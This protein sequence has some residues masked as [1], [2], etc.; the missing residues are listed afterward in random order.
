MDQ[1]DAIFGATPADGKIAIEAEESHSIPPS[2]PSPSVRDAPPIGDAIPTTPMSEFANRVM[3]A[4]RTNFD[5]R[6]SSGTT[7]RLDYCLRTHKK[8]FSDEQMEKLRQ[9]FPGSDIPER[10]FSPITSVKNR[11]LRSILVELVNQVGEPLFKVESSP[12][13]D[14]G[15]DALT[16]ALKITMVEIEGLLQGLEAQG[17]RDDNVPPEAVARLSELVQTTFERRYDDIQNV[18][19]SELRDRAKKMEKKV[20]D[21]FE[22]GGWNKAFM[23]AIDDFCV[24][25]TAVILGPVMRNVA[26]N[27]VKTDKNDVKSYRR[28]VKCIP[29]FERVNPL[30]C[31][32]APDAVEVD[33]G[34][35][36][37]TV[38]F[39]GEE[40]YRLASSAEGTDTSGGGWMGVIVNDILSRHTH[41]GVKLNAFAFDP[42]RR[43]CE[44]NGFDDSSDCTF[45]GVRCFMPM[46]GSELIDMGVVKNLDGSE[47][48]PLEW[49]RTE[50][51]VI[52]NRV[53]YICIHADEL[54]VPVSKACCYNLPGSWWGEAIA[55]MVAQCQCVLNNTARN[56]LL[57]QSMTAAPSGYV[58]DVSRL[59]DKSPDALKWR[60][61]KLFKFT[62][63]GSFGPGGT[64]GPPMGVFPIP[65]TLSDLLAT[66]KAMQQ[67]ADLDSGLPSYSEGQS[68]GASGALRTAQG[69]NTFVENMMRGG[70]SIMTNLD[71]GMISRCARMTADWVLIYDNDQSLKGDVYIRS[72]G[73]IGRVQ[74]TQRDGMRLQI[75]NMCLNSQIL[76]QAI[77]VKGI[78]E[79]FR[80]SLDGLDL[81]PD[82]IMPSKARIKEQDE[83][84]QIAQI[85]KATG[86]AGTGGDVA[87]EQGTGMQSGV[88]PVDSPAP[89][90]EGQVAERRGAA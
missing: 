11:S 71:K 5:H 15:G 76:V 44:A 43:T 62:N 74:K 72:V 37:I 67:Q 6:A 20:W 46:R 81:N 33:D 75:L 42:V 69:L 80:P 31:Y 63:G 32:P 64:S 29:S 26:V 56:M 30:D 54:G 65:S 13:P 57:N 68:A 58:S 53:V 45:E 61:G 3:S 90:V 55:D 1:L 78:L 4:F 47:I 73:L 36:C 7:E 49:Y 52:D 48:K 70:K 24:F 51:V 60:A 19:E 28:T 79:L 41:G 22:E 34:P 85:L 9:Q 35:L 38:R 16:K 89:A 86:G 8:R 83:I 17:V 27:K 21:I 84:M 18:A 23:E 10:I 82:E 87:P 12:L 40:L 59:D 77:G 88:A 25:G 50:S 2:M 66:W 39:T 14:D